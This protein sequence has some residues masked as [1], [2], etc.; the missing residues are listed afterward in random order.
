MIDNLQT[1]VA[2]ARAGTVS[3]ASTQLRVAQSTV[4]QPI[5]KLEQFY[6][7]TLV[8]KR[9]RRLLRPIQFWRYCLNRQLG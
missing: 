5:A 2:L 3:E 4:S 1:L 6:G 7:K 8:Q 9:G